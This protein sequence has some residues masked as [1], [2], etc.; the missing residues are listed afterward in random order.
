MATAANAT[1]ITAT[2]ARAAAQMY[3]FQFTGN[4]RSVLDRE[5]PQRAAGRHVG[6]TL[7]AG[8]Q[9]V[10]AAIA[11]GDRDILHAVLLPR[12][13]LALDAGAGLELPQLLAG[14]G[15]EGFELAGE[16]AGEDD[17]ACRR[18]HARETRN[19]AR[20]L[21]LGLAGQGIDC[22]QLAAG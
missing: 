17:A 9:R 8:E 19:V 1:N 16:L 22:F 4:P 5:N 10:D 20:L 18:Q 21:P 15:I 6:Q 14:V 7:V 3:A 13:R 11:A 12:H 2:A